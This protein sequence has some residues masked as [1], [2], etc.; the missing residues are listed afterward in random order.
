MRRTRRDPQRLSRHC[1]T[2]LPHRFNIRLH[3]LPTD[4]RPPVRNRSVFIIVPI[5]SFPLPHARHPST[6]SRL[7]PSNPRLPPSN[8][9]LH[10]SNPRLP[11][12]NPRLHPSNPRHSREGGNPPRC[13]RRAFIAIPA[14]THRPY[15]FAFDRT[16]PT[17]YPRT[18]TTPSKPHP[19]EIPPCVKHTN[20]QPSRPQSLCMTTL[21]K[22]R[23]IPRS[24]GIDTMR[25]SLTNRN[26]NSCP[27]V[28]RERAAAPTTP[29]I[30]AKAGISSLCT[31]CAQAAADSTYRSKLPSPNLSCR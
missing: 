28:T 22:R 6:N 21:P 30:P 13:V 20:L 11:P 26:E 16:E 27:R 19:K 7:P 8:P 24:T 14:Q 3:S 4:A 17:Y 1:T 23:P 29:V 9:R 15:R 5:P 12:S 25:Q 2:P 18:M 31:D 10:P